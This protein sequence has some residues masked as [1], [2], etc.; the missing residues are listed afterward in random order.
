MNIR[1]SILII[2]AAMLLS[3]S[4]FS[5]QPKPSPDYMSALMTGDIEA[6]TSILNQHPEWV[7]KSPYGT[8]SPIADA[9][10]WGKAEVVKLLVTNNADINAHGVWG[11][12]AL[13]FAANNGDA[14]LVE[15]LLKHKA[16]VNAVDE[17]G[18][19]PIVQSIRSLEVLKLLLAYK[20]DINAHGGKNT[21]YS[22]AIGHSENASPGVIDFILANGVDV[23]I[24]GDEGFY[25]AVLFSDD[26]NLV[27][28]IIPFYAKSTNAAAMPL[29]RGAFEAVLEQG[30]RPMTMA[31]ASAC[32]RLQTNALQRAVANGDDTVVNSMVSANPASVSRK[33]F[34]GWTPLQVAAILGKTELAKR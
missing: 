30:R 1:V 13:H 19:T 33:D 7:N 11:K 31:M 3:E 5:Q 9:A 6:L 12:T 14:K 2:L 17:N 28:K 25:Q 22:Q 26:T 10:Q 23:T 27:M 20:A 15:F 34:L 8:S 4:G 21:L 18:F 16:D 29:L 32:L 24:S